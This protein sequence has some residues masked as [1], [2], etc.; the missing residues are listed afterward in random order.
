M[1]TQHGRQNRSLAGHTGLDGP[2]NA[3]GIGP[4]ARLW[5][6]PPHR[7][8]Q[9]NHGTL[10]PV[11]LKLEQEGSITAEW[12][13]PDNNRKAKLYRLTK[14]GRKLL[15]SETHQGRQTTEIIGRFLALRGET[16]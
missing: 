9:P 4:P 10:Y 7:A 6:R 3:G 16:S 5:H 15:A 8:D 12:G 14:A 13:V 1:G 2:E 11:L